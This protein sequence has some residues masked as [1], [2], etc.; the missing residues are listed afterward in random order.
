MQKTSNVIDQEYGL[1]RSKVATAS[2]TACTLATFGS[3][4]WPGFTKA[5][6]CKSSITGTPDIMPDFSAEPLP[7]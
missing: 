6:F 1:W 7:V 3:D 5:C 2:S 4:P